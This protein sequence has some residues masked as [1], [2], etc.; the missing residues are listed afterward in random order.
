M[1]KA[2][3]LSV[4]AIASMLIPAN[5]HAQ[6]GAAK[7]AT[8]LSRF[9]PSGNTYNDVW[10]YVD[11]TGREYAILGTT[12][13]T[14]IVN[15]T[16]PT[17]PRQ[18]A[19][20]SGP[21]S[22]WRDM[23][24]YRH[25]AYV[26]TEGGGGVQIIDLADPENPRMVQTWGASIFRN[27]HNVAIDTGTGT[28]Y[29]CG[30]N[31]GTPIIDIATDPENPS[32]IGRYTSSYVHDLCVQDGYAHLGEISSGRYRIL[33]ISNPANPSV[34]GNLSVSSCHNA[35]PSRDGQVAVA[36]SERTGGAMTVIDISNKRLPIRV[37]TFRTGSSGTSIHNAFILDRVSHAAYYSEGY[38]AVDVSDAAN[39]VRVAYYDTSSSTSGFSGSWGCYPFQPSGIVYMSDF[40]NGLHLISSKATSDRYGTGTAGSGGDMPTIHTFGAAY[41][42][43]SNFRIDVSNVAPNAT[44]ALLIG[45]GETNVQIMGANVLVDPTRQLLILNARANAAGEASISIPIG[46]SRPAKL[47]AQFLVLDSGAPRGIAASRGL[48]F[49]LINRT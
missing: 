25:Y 23:R 9:D 24:T 45:V 49:D 46:D 27:A 17:N 3:A 2:T 41:S 37:G 22:T 10:G 48:S 18:V 36:T 38:Q 32:L 19:Y 35:W 30:T 44:V 28:L 43:N 6:V 1:K 26:V 12:R 34:S 42:G 8:L 33:D 20:F 31:N 13:G 29:P 15:C 21:S 39:P 5:G 14:Y 16:D 40:Q 11:P 7:N 47:F 4:A